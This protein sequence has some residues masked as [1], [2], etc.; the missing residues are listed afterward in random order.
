L[1][2]FFPKS[3]LFFFS[4]TEKEREVLGSCRK[5]GFLYRV[6][7]REVVMVVVVVVVHVGWG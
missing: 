2:G 1:K 3:H 7:G 5:L 6:W 4:E